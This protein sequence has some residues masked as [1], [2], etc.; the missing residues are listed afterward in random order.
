MQNP[1]EVR[2]WC[3]Q[4]QV[5]VPGR[6]S[7]ERTGN[8]CLTNFDWC[9]R[10]V[11][12]MRRIWLVDS[13]QLWFQ[14][15]RVQAACGEG[16]FFC[17]SSLQ[18]ETAKAIFGQFSLKNIEV[19]WHVFGVVKLKGKRCETELQ[20]ASAMWTA[21]DFEVGVFW[22]LGAL[23]SIYVD[24]NNT[25]MAELCQCFNSVCTVCKW[26]SSLPPKIIPGHELKPHVPDQMT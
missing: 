26:G 13:E 3:S 12:R 17:F 22:P 6:G 14:L 23:D 5:G 4:I 7:T 20:V 24:L 16:F 8:N 21:N 9:G 1:R 25:F 18:S 19:W 10:E 11:N 15:E 2:V